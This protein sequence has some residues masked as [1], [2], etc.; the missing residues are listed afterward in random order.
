LILNSFISGGGGGGAGTVTSVSVVTANG[1]SGSV[2]TAT[3][4]PAIT[5]TLGAITPTSVNGI[6]L[7]GTGGTT[8]T[9]PST[10]ASV[11]RIDAAQTFA[12]TQTFS[13]SVN[14]TQNNTQVLSVGSASFVFRLTSGSGNTQ[15]QTII[16]VDNSL[17]S[18]GAQA[19]GFTTGQ[20]LIFTVS[21]SERRIL[22]CAL[23]V[24]NTVNTVGA[25]VGDLGIYTQTAGATAALR[26]TVGAS[27]MTLIDAYDIA[28]NTTTGTKIGTATTQKLGFWNATPIVQPAT[29]GAASTFAANTSLIANDTATFDGYTIGQVVKALRNAGILA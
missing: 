21:N 27:A 19:F 22:R 9:F 12:G 6:T 29:G 10:T 25:E 13:G 23:K 4:T 18:V 1:V 17:T 3:T 26:V 2:A 11:A 28:L 5:L 15:A 14:L 20:G 7:S 16:D 24:V 8:M